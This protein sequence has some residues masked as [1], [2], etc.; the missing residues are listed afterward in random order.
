MFTTWPFWSCP[1]TLTPELNNFVPFSIFVG[2]ENNFCCLKFGSFYH[3]TWVWG[4]RVKK[5]SEFIFK[6]I[7]QMF[8]Q[9]VAT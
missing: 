2:L 8:E 7:L 6:F 4:P 1:K 9:N 3:L 5:S